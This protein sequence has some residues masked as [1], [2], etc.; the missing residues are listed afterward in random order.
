MGSKSIRTM[1]GTHDD[2][3]GTAYA[4]I[5]QSDLDHWVLCNVKLECDTNEI[6]EGTAMWLFH[7]LM[8]KLASST[9]HMR[10]ASKQKD[11]TGVLSRA[12]KTTLTTYPQV[13][14][15]LL[16]T[17][18]TDEKLLTRRMTPPQSL[19][20]RARPSTIRKRVDW[21]RTLMWGR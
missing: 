2:T 21:K 7:F 1:D 13:V 20:H 12:K 14:N 10:L 15:Y 5:L 3:N 19:S 17:Y 9:L 11:R 6:H 4:R 8:K 16:R 18:E